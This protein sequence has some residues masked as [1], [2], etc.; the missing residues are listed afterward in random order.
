MF[1]TRLLLMLVFLLCVP[2]VSFGAEC[3]STPP[4]EVN[5]TQWS[6]NSLLS[7]D[8]KWKFLSI[9]PNSPDE[10]AALYIQNVQTSMQWPLGWIERNGTAFW[11]GDSKR[12]FLRDEYA[13]DDTMIRVFDVTEKMPQE[14]K[15]LNDKIEKAVLAHVPKDKITQWLHYPEVCFG[16]KDSSTIIVVADAPLDPKAG[17]SGVW[18]D[19]KLTV[20]VVSRQVLAAVPTPH[21]IRTST[22][23]G[24]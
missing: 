1:K 11:S 6:A 16:D 7:P 20:N 17:G 21:R 9:G 23:T 8:H 12:L 3:E 2:D 22:G 4:K 24:R 13:A 18:F 15:G 14:I 19:L 10:K 5:L